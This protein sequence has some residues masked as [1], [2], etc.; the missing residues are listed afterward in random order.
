MLTKVGHGIAVQIR[1]ARFGFVGYFRRYGLVGHD[2]RLTRERSRVR[3]S[4]PIRCGAGSTV[5]VYVPATDE[6]RV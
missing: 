5:I 1:L 2:A 3:A 6:T 4:V